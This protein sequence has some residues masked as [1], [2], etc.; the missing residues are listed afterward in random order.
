MRCFFH[1]NVSLPW[2][3]MERACNAER[4]MFGGGQNKSGGRQPAV[5]TKRAH[6]G[7][8]FSPAEYIRAPRLA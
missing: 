3:A 7:E 5:P 4:T 8:R 6:D 1:V 2:V